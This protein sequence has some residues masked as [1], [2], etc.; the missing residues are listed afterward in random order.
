M[1]SSTVENYLKAIRNLGVGNEAPV[2]VGRIAGELE[3]TPGT[4]TTMMKH[5]R[6][7]GLV[8][9]TPRRGVRLTAEGDAAAL[10]VLRRH[11]L[12]E[13]FLV[14][15]MGLDWGDVHHEAEVLEH[16]VSDR[17]LARIDDMLGHPTADPHGAPIP[18]AEGRMPVQPSVSL[19]DAAPGGYQLVRVGEDDGGLLAWL[20]DHDLR[21]GVRFELLRHDRPAGILQL[22]IEGAGHDLP[23]GRQA[24]DRLMVQALGAEA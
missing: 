22:R 12:I 3:V 19:A 15:V 1:P 10:R 24:A 18:D 2:A 8:T 20:A 13:L 21:P 5:L 14:E 23:L 4:V 11:R 6:S 7:R 16:A 9:Y 17:L